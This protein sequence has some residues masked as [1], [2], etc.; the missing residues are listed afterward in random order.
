M[1]YGVPQAMSRHVSLWLVAPSPYGPPEDRPLC[2]YPGCR[3]RPGRRTRCSRCGRMVGPCCWNDHSMTC[4]GCAGSEPE[5]EPSTHRLCDS[6]RPVGSRMCPEPWTPEWPHYRR[7]N[8]AECNYLTEGWCTFCWGRYC[9]DHVA[10]A[11]HRCHD[12]EEYTDSGMF[13]R[14]M[15]PVHYPV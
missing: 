15:M 7:C 13:T 6:A 2:G 10:P 4:K 1:T 14:R 3:H 12:A 5:P 9:G 11:H 8:Y